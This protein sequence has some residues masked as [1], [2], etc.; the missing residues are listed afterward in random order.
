[1]TQ[2]DLDGAG[3]V[4]GTLAGNAPMLRANA[5]AGLVG[6]L[7]DQTQLLSPAGFGNN[8]TASR[9]AWQLTPASAGSLTRVT[10][11]LP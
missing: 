7:S 1:M 10:A 4:L 6:A 9:D 5:V 11:N 3:T 2:L 8:E